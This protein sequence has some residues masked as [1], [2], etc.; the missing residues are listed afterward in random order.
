MAI[1]QRRSKIYEKIWGKQTKIAHNI[2]RTG[3]AE[4]GLRS[5]LPG[6]DIGLNPGTDTPLL[7]LFEAGEKMFGSRG[8]PVISVGS[9]VVAN[10]LVTEG[11]DIPAVCVVGCR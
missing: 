3:Y 11:C 9:R 7:S 10:G 5:L 2:N 6:W 1:N 4:P 8:R